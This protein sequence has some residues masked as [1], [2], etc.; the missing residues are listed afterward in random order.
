MNRFRLKE[1]NRL[2]NLS[3]RFSPDITYR[4]ESVN[5]RNYDKQEALSQRNDYIECISRYI[6]QTP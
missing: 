6:Y 4:I 2:P 1:D 3:V 5:S